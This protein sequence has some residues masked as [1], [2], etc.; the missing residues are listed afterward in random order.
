MM[1]APPILLLALVL[2]SVIGYALRRRGSRIPSPP[3]NK[4]HL[5][6]G[7]KPLPFLGN[8]LD[9]DLERPWLTYSVWRKKYGPLVYCQLLGQ[10]VVIINSGKVARQ[11]LDQRSSFYSSRPS[12]CVGKLF[13]IEFNTALLPYG[14]EW[15]IHRRMFHQA[16]RLEATE[17]YQGLYQSSAIKLL[18]NLLD[19]PDDFESHLQLYV[20]SITMGV[21]Y[22]YEMVPLDAPFVKALAEFTKLLNVGLGPERN[23]MLTAF[24]FLA[25]IPAWFPGVTFKRD[26][27]RSQELS[28]KSLDD[29]FEYVRKNMAAGSSARSMVSDLLNKL[30]VNKDYARQEKAIKECAASAYVARLWEFLS[31]AI[32]GFDTSAATLSAFLMVMILYPDAQRRAQDEIDSFLANNAFPDFSHRTSLPYVEAVLRETMRWHSVAPLALPHTTSCDDIFEGYFIPKGTMIMAN[33][34]EIHNE[35]SEY[36]QP[37][38]F[39]P[40]RYLNTDGTLTE[41]PLASR[42]AFGFGRR[43]CPGKWVADAVL[44]MGMVSILALF[45]IEKGKDG[46]DREIEVVPNFTGGVIRRPFP[47]SCSIVCRSAPREH[48]VRSDGDDQGI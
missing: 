16:L 35:E 8:I 29:P 12:S 38:L 20:I 41:D 1:A 22:G 37:H 27:L 34:W 33:V 26:A 47:Y 42:V 19:T 43:H 15:R 40:E 44:W 6:P 10:N 36:H 7:P 23:A 11:L 13:G 45:R 30:D 3:N 9:V 4:F 21:L 25:K 5:P 48:M 17:L 14:P 32:A 24:P 2:G 18:Q 28:F 46:M 31:F 39:N